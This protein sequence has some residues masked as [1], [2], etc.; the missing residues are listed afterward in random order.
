MKKA[1]LFFLLFF[2][3]GNLFLFAG[4]MGNTADINTIAEKICRFAKK[5]YNHCAEYPNKDEKLCTEKEKIIKHYIS[6][7]YP[8]IL[9]LFLSIISKNCYVQCMFPERWDKIKNSFLP[10]CIKHMKDFLYSLKKQNK[11]K[12]KERSG[13]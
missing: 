11:Q 5:Q 7:K 1:G 3:S 8:D 13:G 9:N 4:K 12:N 10:F 6:L 2:F